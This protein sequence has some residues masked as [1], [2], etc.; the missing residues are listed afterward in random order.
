MKIKYVNVYMADRAYGGPE[1][2][3]WY[4]TYGEAL[5]TIPV[6]PSKAD[7][8][9]EKVNRWAERRNASRPSMSSVASEGVFWV[10]LEDDPA[11]NWPEQRPHYE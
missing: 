8:L 3:G 4:Y 11:S 9:L 7:R 1:E 6:L 5:K 2:G 10:N